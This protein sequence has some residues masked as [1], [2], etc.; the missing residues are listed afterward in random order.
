MDSLIEN[1]RRILD[2]AREGDEDNQDFA[3]LIRPDG[4]LH[5]VM[6]SPFSIEAAAI[7]AGAQ[8]A[9]RITRSRD[10]VRVEGRRSGK[11]TMEQCVLQERSQRSQLLPDQAL[12]RITSPLL[13]SCA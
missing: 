6:E 8:S 13:T 11:S 7:H 4:V 10:G 9:F 3:L 2:V 1:A 12:Y 5:F